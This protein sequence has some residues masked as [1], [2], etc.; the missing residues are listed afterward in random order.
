MH[1]ILSK[2][3][4]WLPFI[5]IQLTKLKKIP[6]FMFQFYQIRNFPNFLPRINDVYLPRTRRNHLRECIAHRQTKF[7]TP[8]PSI[9]EFLPSVFNVSIRGKH[10]SS[11]ADSERAPKISRKIRNVYIADAHRW[12]RYTD[13]AMPRWFMTPT[14]C[15]ATHK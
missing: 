11:L 2:I 4:F 12:F 7:V 14:F 6:E 15:P 9:P 13:S 8:S 1:V 3:N 5:Q 10:W